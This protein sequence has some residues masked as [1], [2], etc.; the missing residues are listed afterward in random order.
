MHLK[1]LLNS[2]LTT[3]PVLDADFKDSF[4]CNFLSRNP[5]LQLGVSV[6]AAGF[7]PTTP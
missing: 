7:E 2:Y 1:N 4:S 3:C 6:G 5:H